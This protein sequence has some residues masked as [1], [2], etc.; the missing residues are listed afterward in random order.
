M[1]KTILVLAALGLILT[2]AE[3]KKKSKDK[4]QEYV[5]TQAVD[6]MSYALGV[7]IG[8][9]I[10]G[11]LKTIPGGEYSVDALLKGFSQALKGEQTLMTNEFA[12]T[13]VQD[14]MM[15]AYDELS[16]QQKEEGEKF[17]IEN[18]QKEGVV[19]TASGLQY[20]VITEGTGVKPVATDIVKVHY[21][22]F[23][24]DGTKFDSSKD[25]NEPAEFPVNQVIP[26][27]TEGVQLMPVG[28]VYK[29]YIPYELGYGERGAG[30]VVPPY[31]TLIFEV[32][33]LD[34]NPEE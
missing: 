1:K 26:G 9:D 12:R 16:K 27:W 17:L 34:V 6:S 8:T 25:R 33:L 11:T 30:T 14:Y 2:P 22:G 31:S 28:S 20:E 10:T 23:L 4:N 13:Y 24:L 32:E 7:S 19:E 18:K 5:L 29:F 15:A 21:E 3:A